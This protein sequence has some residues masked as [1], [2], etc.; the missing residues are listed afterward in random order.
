MGNIALRLSC[1]QDAA[2]VSPKNEL[3]SLGLFHALFESER[4]QP[5]YA[6]MVRFRAPRDSE[7]YR[8]LLSDGFDDVEF[9]A[10]IV[11]AREFLQS[12]STTKNG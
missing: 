11:R 4:R 1:F 2:E 12:R 8:E 5:A 6:E 10:E 9:R 7:L 3:A